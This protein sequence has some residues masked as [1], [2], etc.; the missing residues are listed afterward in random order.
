MRSC[1]IRVLVLT[2]GL[3]A[4]LSAVA[5]QAT[6]PPREGVSWPQAYQER[7]AQQ[8]TAFTYTHAY[9][10]LMARIRANRL[11]VSRG[12]MTMTAAAPLGGLVVSGTKSIPV[13]LATYSNTPTAPYP[14]GNLQTELFDG[15]WPT[16]TMTDY[17]HEISYGVFTVTG[18]VFPWQKL[19]N[20]DSF[21]EGGCNGLCPGAGTGEFLK[22]TLD[23]ND[24]AIDFSQYDNDGPDG[25][26]NSGDDDGFVD[27]VAFVH[28]ENGG[29]CGNGNL[30]AHRWMYSGWT[31]AAYTTNDARAG[32]GSIQIDDY[33]LMPALACDGSTMIQIGVFAHEFG[34]A[35]GLPDLYDTDGDNGDSEGIGN[36][37]LMAAGSWGGDGQSPEK[38]S[39]MSA[40]SKQFLGWITPTQVGADVDP[41]SLADVETHGFAYKVPISATQYFLVSNR[42]QTGFD[43]ALPAGGVLIWRINETVLNSGLANNRVNA[44]ESN[45][46]VGLEEAD[47]KDDLDSAANRGDAGDPYPG[48]SGNRAFDKTSHPMSSGRVAVC[49]IS[50]SGNPMTAKILVT[51]DTCADDGGGGE[52]GHRGGCSSIAL[53]PTNG[54]QRFLSMALLLLPVLLAAALA[55][56]DLWRRRNGTLG[57]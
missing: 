40:W 15:P 45:P 4:L 33:V 55:S 6:I 44:D 42:Q 26:P 48:S 36:W 24:A 27:F 37:G 8:P 19:A 12:E 46:G 38:P 9:L 7:L 50:D 16:G 11:A 14:P 21:Y 31:G 53:F 1:G 28:P 17:Y 41:A 20:D 13:L 25:A 43:S 49:G 10:P 32:G 2:V 47:G 30:W 57:T 35:F 5:V 54:G 3:L 29:E 18:T 56:R 51:T 52:D 34:H 22:E 23:L 39:H